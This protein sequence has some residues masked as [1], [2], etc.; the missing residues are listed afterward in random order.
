MKTLWIEKLE[1]FKNWCVWRKVKKVYIDGHALGFVTHIWVQ[2]EAG[3]SIDKNV[4]LLITIYG[5][6]SRKL[7]DLKYELLKCGI[8]VIDL[9][10]LPPAHEDKEGWSQ[11][12]LESSYEA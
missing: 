9:C 3:E 12:M 8:H 5:S 10:G 1:N 2:R 7:L 6:A 4:D 11:H